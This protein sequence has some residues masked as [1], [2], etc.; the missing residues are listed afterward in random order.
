MNTPLKGQHFLI[1]GRVQGVFY[2]RFA[3]QEA[4]AL[5]ITGW[6]QNLEDGRVEIK[7]FGS[8]ESL[9]LYLQK[10]QQGPL[11]A[12]VSEVIVRDIDVEEFSGFEVRVT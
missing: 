3:R 4:Q 9:Q 10:L 2:R 8:H 1:S 12:K 6:T 7:A 11:A 5:G